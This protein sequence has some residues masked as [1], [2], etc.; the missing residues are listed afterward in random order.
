MLLS[1]S[2]LNLLHP[3]T[4][5]SP[6]DNNIEKSFHISSPCFPHG[7]AGLSRDFPRELNF[8]SSSVGVGGFREWY[9]SPE[10]YAN[11][12]NAYGRFGVCFQHIGSHFQRQPVV[13]C[14]RRMRK[15]LNAGWYAV[16]LSNTNFPKLVGANFSNLL[17]VGR[18]LKSTVSDKTLTPLLKV[19]KKVTK[20][21]EKIIQLIPSLPLDA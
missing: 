1:S 8:R 18:A 3:H 10:N 5:S 16:V 19:K 13:G 14:H 12:Y 9:F 21:W 20:L 2:K 15:G 7:P 6:N 11:K 4:T 17:I